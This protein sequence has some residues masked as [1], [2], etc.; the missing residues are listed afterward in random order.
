MFHS[1]KNRINLERTRALLGFVFPREATSLGIAKWNR[2][3]A[4]TVYPAIIKTRRNE[5]RERGS[6]G[7]K[8][9]RFP[10]ERSRPSFFRLE[11]KM[12]HR[13]GIRRPKA[14]GLPKSNVEYLLI[15]YKAD[16]KFNVL[17]HIPVSPR[18]VYPCICI[19]EALLYHMILYVYN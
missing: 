19:A 1:R 5:R 6:T 8:R 13:P 11:T 10:T 12:R 14:R 15:M 17:S 18:R 7:T 4:T 9:G 3:T 16:P 2:A